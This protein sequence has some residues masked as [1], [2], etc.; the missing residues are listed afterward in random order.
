MGV[1]G[2]RKVE[3]GCFESIYHPNSDETPFMGNR[4]K[5]LNTD[6]KFVFNY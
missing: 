5:R 1:T 6:Y 3:T 4:K 2:S